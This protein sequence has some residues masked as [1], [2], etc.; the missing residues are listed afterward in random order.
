[1]RSIPL[2]AALLLLGLCAAPPAMAQIA[3]EWPVAC[4]VGETCE[5]QHYV[6]HGSGTAAQDYRCGSVTYKGHN[7]TDIRVLTMADERKGVNVLA[8][9]PGTVLRARDGMADVS[10]AVIG[11]D[12][13]KDR[14]CGNALV[15]GHADGFETQYCHMAQGSLMVKPGESVTAGQPIGRVGLSGDTEFPH[16]HITVR[17]D[18]KVIDPF[19]YGETEGACSGG[20]SLWSPAVQ[21]TLAYKAGT[22]LNAG[23]APRPVTMDDI[24]NGLGQEGLTS[25]S[26]AV[27]AYVRAITLRQGD[28]QRIVLTGPNGPLLD[29]SEPPLPSNKDQVYMGVGRKRPASGWP[30]GRYAGTYTVTR[31]GKVVVEKTLGAELGS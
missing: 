4:Q 7:G 1:M 2:F 20:V 11:H 21:Q 31:E 18:G 30:P 8:A 28:V 12:A 9:A 3:F 16:L 13:I 17:H 6:D 27:L 24:D 14:D 10:V 23:L 5:I 25:E 26:P 15:I 22:V 29:H 19:A